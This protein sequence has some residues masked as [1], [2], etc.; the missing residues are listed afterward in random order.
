MPARFNEVNRLPA[1]RH[2]WHSLKGSRRLLLRNGENVTREV[3]QGSLRE[4]LD[5]NPALMIACARTDALKELL[6]GR[7]E[8]YARR[9]LFLQQTA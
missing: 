1:D 4:P 5:T 2:A 9:L 6:S 3:D 7:R 8:I